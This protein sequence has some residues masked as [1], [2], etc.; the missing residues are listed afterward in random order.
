MGG[1]AKG[2]LRAPSGEAIVARLAAM[3]R[4][5]GE[6]VLVGDAAAYASIGIEAIADEPQGIGP[7][8]GLIALL[9][10]ARGGHALAIA[11]DMPFVS[12]ALLA[13]LVNAE[14]A[15]IVA[16]RRDGKWE[17]FFARYDAARVL[18][19]AL[20][21]AAR[22]ARSMHGLLSEAGTVELPLDAHEAAELRDWDTPD[23]VGA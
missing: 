20:A 2:L 18:P 12:D 10:R 8:G 17:P 9:Q 7:L 1:A 21:R 13:K 3:L 11:C 19:I 14:D 4:S 23:D 5:R 15:A 16:A 6:V 22:G